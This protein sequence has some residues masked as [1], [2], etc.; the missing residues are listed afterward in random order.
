VTEGA[1]VG[2]GEA[3]LLATIDQI[4]PL[5]VNFTQSCADLMRLQKAVKNGELKRGGAVSVQL[6]LNDGSVYHEP[7]KLL[8]SDLVVD[9]STGTVALRA[10]VPN[11]KHELLPGMYATVRF[12]EGDMDDRI[13]IPQAAVLSNPQGQFVMVVDDKSMAQ[14]RPIKI[15]AMSHGDFVVEAGLA[16]GD[17]VI[18]NGFMKAK[19]GAPVKPVPWNPAG[20][21]PAAAPAPANK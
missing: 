18:V 14:I 19:P 3:T 20:A 7:A 6:V 2:H 8:F 10:E 15:G 5:Y 9:Q 17:K 4:D 13:K 12:P 11:S 16:P 1:L 21:A